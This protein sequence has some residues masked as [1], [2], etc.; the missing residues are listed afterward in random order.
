M[1]IVVGH[2][3]NMPFRPNVVIAFDVNGK[4]LPDESL[5]KTI[6][7]VERTDLKIVAVG[8]ED[9][10]FLNSDINSCVMSS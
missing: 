7:M 6:N 1:A 9:V 2:N 4:I 5:K 10:S 3:P 8:E